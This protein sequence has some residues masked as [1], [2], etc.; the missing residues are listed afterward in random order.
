MRKIKIGIVKDFN[1]V[2]HRSKR[3]MLSAAGAPLNPKPHAGNF[4]PIKLIPIALAVAILLSFGAILTL[5]ENGNVLID[6]IFV[7]IQNI[8]PDDD[9]QSAP[10][11][12]SEAVNFPRNAPVESWFCEACSPCWTVPKEEAPHLRTDRCKRW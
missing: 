1:N 8:F 6:E 4:S 11:Q 2:T 7:K 9:S 5:A 3:E 10:P 12:N